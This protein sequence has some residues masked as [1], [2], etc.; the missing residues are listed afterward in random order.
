MEKVCPLKSISVKQAEEKQFALIECIMHNFSGLQSLTRGDLGVKKE[1]NKPEYTLKAE[2]SIAEFFNSEDCILVRG[3][4]TG[5]IRYGLAAMFKA[6]DKILIHDAPA[7][8]TTQVSIDM[9]GLK[10]VKADYNNLSELE[11]VLKQTKGLKGV[12]VQISR[13]KKYD[14]YQANEV[15]NLLKKYNLP[16]ICDD[17]YAAL[18]VNKIGSQLGADLST[19]S[20]FKLQ[21]PEG[22]GCIVGKADIIAKIK[23]MHYSGGCQVQGFEAMEVLRGLVYAP[24]MLAIQA[25]QAEILIK[26]IKKAKNADI[27]DA[28]IANAQSKVILVELAKPIAKQVLVEAEKLGCLPNPVGSESKYELVP[29]FYKA[30]GT[31]LKEDPTL[32]DR[33]IR[34]NPNRASAKTVLKVLNKAIKLASKA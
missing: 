33:M 15:I 5:A 11:K 23:K 19:F 6:N 9:L 7:Y 17:N 22:I 14:S 26:E 30:S 3:S 24:V 32:I 10:V 2:R 18:K 13:Q 8:T 21:G 29:L 31:F 4:G 34:I 25:Q 27:K 20:C 16:V 12:L 28:Y 1:N